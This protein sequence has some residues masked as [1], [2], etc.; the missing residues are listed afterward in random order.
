MK[1]ELTCLRC[2]HT[3]LRRTAKLPVFCPACHSAG[4]RTEA[5]ARVLKIRETKAA[6]KIVQDNP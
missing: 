2:H 5:S 6:R 1:S 4:W 3:W